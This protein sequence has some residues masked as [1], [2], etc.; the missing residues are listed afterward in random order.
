[1]SGT[2]WLIDVEGCP[3]DALRNAERLRDV[4]R[5][6]ILELRL[7]VVG[8]PL[9]HQFPGAGGL[10][11]MYL[12]S[13]SHLTCHTFPEFGTAT[14]NLYCCSVRPEWNWEA[15]L[16]LELGAERIHVRRVSRGS[17]AKPPALTAA[18][19]ERR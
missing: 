19:E 1:M 10:T 5:R 2:E 13:E 14:F 6:V 17:S 16:R 7:K 8:E 18:T 3:S 11:G 15:I 4:C 9:W 12:L